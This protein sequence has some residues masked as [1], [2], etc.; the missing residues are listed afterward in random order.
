MPSNLESLFGQRAIAENQEFFK[1]KFVDCG[2][3]DRAIPPRNIDI[4]LGYRGA[5]CN[6]KCVWCYDKSGAYDK[7]D[8]WTPGKVGQLEE[9]VNRV[10]NWQKD[11]FKIEEIYLA[12]GGEPALFPEVASMIIEKFARAQRN[13]WLTTNGIKIKEPLFSTLIKK[14]RGILQSMPGTD[15]KSYQANGG[16]DHF[17]EALNT[18]K[19]VVITRNEQQTSLEI[20]VTHVLSANT[21][22]SLEQFIMQLEAIGVDEFR[23]RYDVFSS[24]NAE[25]NTKGITKVK[26]IIEKYP[27]LKMKILLK[28]PQEDALPENMH[29]YSPFLWPTWNPQHGVFPCAHSTEETNRVSDVEK[30]GIYSLVD[31]QYSLEDTINP[32]CHRRCPSRRCVA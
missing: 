29:C 18:L 10:I 19:Q 27:D 23:V 28:S 11:G 4:H 5:P 30:N 7:P 22:D 31:L 3:I 16:F 12:G 2:K 8:K 26:E 24:A 21:I 6:L 14:G 15:Q 9:E 1:R 17:E 20:D 13:V 32:N 25:Q